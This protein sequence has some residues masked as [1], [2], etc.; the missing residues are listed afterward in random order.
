[1]DFDSY[2]RYPNEDSSAKNPDQPNED[3][4][5][6][7]DVVQNARHNQDQDSRKQC[8]EG[9]GQGVVNRHS[10]TTGLRQQRPGEDQDQRPKQSKSSVE[11]SAPRLRKAHIHSIRTPAILAVASA[12][13]RTSA[14]VDQQEMNAEEKEDSPHGTAVGKPETDDCAGPAGS[15]SYRS[16]TVGSMCIA[17]R[18]G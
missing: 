15:Y 10:S 6:S 2:V 5:N 1:M 11:H 4:V 18:A 8:K 16:A 3:Q 17:R 13:P 9:S 7:Y 14:P 12:K